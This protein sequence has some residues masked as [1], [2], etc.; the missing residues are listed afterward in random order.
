[1]FLLNKKILSLTAKPLNILY[2]L[3]TSFSATQALYSLT[4]DRSDE[5]ED[6]NQN[7]LRNS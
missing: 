7:V 3:T 4:N 6:E 1:M 2:N 5:K